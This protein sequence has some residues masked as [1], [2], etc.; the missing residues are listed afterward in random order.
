MYIVIALISYLAGIV[1]GIIVPNYLL[2]VAASKLKSETQTLNSIT[3][4]TATNTET[5]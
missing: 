3:T 1:T 4:S 5:K 2:K